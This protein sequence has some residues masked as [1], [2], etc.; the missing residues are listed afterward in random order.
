MKNQNGAPEEAPE[1]SYEE[2]YARLQAILERLEAADLPLADSLDLYE[3]GVKLAE[4][5]GVLLEEAELRVR[6][7]EPDGTVSELNGDA[8][9]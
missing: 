1:L 8:G 9:R 5:C 6:K 4:R 3:A 7:W 2:S